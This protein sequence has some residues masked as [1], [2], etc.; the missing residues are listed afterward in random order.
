MVQSA[1]VF[2]SSK[3]TP[4]T[5]S[6]KTITRKTRVLVMQGGFA[7]PEEDVLSRAVV[8]GMHKYDPARFP[9]PQKPLK[10]VA[11]GLLSGLSPLKNKKASK[12]QPDKVRCGR[13]YS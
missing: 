1:I 13:G 5:I 8:R 7:M 6:Q 9:A 11:R 12:D 10:A 3:K 4:A 2:V